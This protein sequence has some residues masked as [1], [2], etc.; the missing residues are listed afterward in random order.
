MNQLSRILAGT[1]LVASLV[2]C[3]ASE[4]GRPDSTTFAAT[5]ASERR[6]ALRDEAPPEA[7]GSVVAIQW[8]DFD[9]TLWNDPGFRKRF[10]ESYIAATDIEPTVTEK[11]REHLQQVMEFIGAGKIDKA[12][13]TLTKQGGP[14]SSAVFDFMRG[15]LHFQ[16]EEFS[17]AAEAYS[18]AVEKASNFR[19]AWKN[20]ALVQVRANEFAPAATALTRVIELGGG[21]SITYGLLGYAYTNLEQHM[22]A[23][24][25]YRMAVLLDPITPDWPMGLARSFFKQRRFA[26]AVTLL[27]S[28]L[29]KSPDRAD[30]WMLQANAYIGLQEPLR[31]AENFEIADR[32]G[33]ANFESLST[34][35]NIYLNEQLFEPGVDS[36]LR[37]L[38][39]QP[40]GEL[41]RFFGALNVLRAR[42]AHSE[43]EALL[44]G[45]ERIVGDKVLP[46][47]RKELLKARVRLAAA[48]GEGEADATVLE[49][50]VQLDPL[51]GE[52]LILLGQHYGKQGDAER[53]AF[54]FERAA[55]L[56]EFEADAK[57]RHA[58]LFVGL[59][60]YREA[61]PLLRRAQSIRP[62][63]N[64]QKY[65]E[66]IERA[67]QGR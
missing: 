7:P 62:R 25:A 52:A 9:L 63:E 2:A 41:K 3:R 38:E 8:T 29:E 34:L 61:L 37:A 66:Q 46:D 1:A 6:L 17:L 53:A 30:L 14:A 56:E 21:D 58:Q 47:D 28:L 55:G 5:G 27:G 57:V 18:V 16:A 42:G 44:D 40:E 26:E 59:G 11:E 49:E 35:G 39:L 60:Q 65:L 67:A 32:L 54:Y 31:A 10:T 24:S 51:D 36:Y 64:I 43:A 45:I 19:R 13:G 22:S 15:N 12:L 50:I 20:L 33:A 23:E 48:T 4:G